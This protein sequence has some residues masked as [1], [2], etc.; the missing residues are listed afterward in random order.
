MFLQL[1]DEQDFRQSALQSLL[2]IYQLTSDWGK[3]IETAEKLVKL[4][5]HELK[6]QIAHFYC[7]LALQE[8][9]SDNLDNAL[10]F[11]QKAGQMD[12]LC[13]RVSIMYGRIYIAR[14]EKNKAID[15][16]MKVIEQDKEMVSE[17]LPMLFEC[18]QSQ[19]DPA[20]WEAYLRQC[21]ESNCGAIAELYLADIIEEKEGIEAAQLYIN[22]QLERHPT[23][24]LFYRLMRYHLAEAEE[25]RAKESAALS[26]NDW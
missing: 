15:V 17:T 8:M 6:E 24:R 25:G 7:E 13:A 22:R 12:P 16:L 19:G 10:S 3:A 11:L 26:I 9:S 5:Q 4:G 23:M 21:V 2:A 1:I 18:F 14:D 20:R